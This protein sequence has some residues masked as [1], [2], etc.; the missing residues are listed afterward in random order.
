MSGPIGKVFFVVDPTCAEHV[1]MAPQAV[2]FPG[3]ECCRAVSNS[4]ALRGQADDI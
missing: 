4:E 1:G 3:A 2:A